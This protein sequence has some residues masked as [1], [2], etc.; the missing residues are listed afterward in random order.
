MSIE[1]LFANGN[2]PN[3]MIIITDQ[4]R[5]LSEWPEAYRSTLG[6]KLAA[7]QRLMTNGLYFEQAFT[8]AC[9]CS[10]SRAT[11]QTSQY[12]IVTG[13]TLT[14]E[15]ALPSPA[16]YANLTSV[17]SA[18]GYGCYWIGKWHLLWPNEPGTTNTDLTPWGWQAYG[19]PSPSSG[20][21]IYAWDPPDAGIT[22]DD[23]YL[24]GGTK[25]T[26]ATNRNDQR[27]VANA[28]SFLQAPPAGPW[29][30]VVSL[31]NP[32]DVHLG[33]EGL[34]HEFYERS[35]YEGLDVPLP[36]TVYQDVSKMPRGQSYSTWKNQSAGHH[37]TRHHF[38]DFYAYLVEYVDGQI[39]TILDAMNPSQVD[40]TLIVRFSDH[41]EMGL[42][43]NLVEKFVNA[44]GQCVHV[45]LVFSNPVAWPSA[46]TTQSLASTVDLVPTFAGLLGVQ[47]DQ[48]SFVGADLS[49][50]LVNPTQPVQDFVH[51]T[52]DDEGDT[53]VPS[54][55]R[56]IRSQQWAYAVYLDSV[57][58]ATSGYLDADWEM[59][60]LV[61]DPEER[62]NLAGQGL[63]QQDFLDSLLQAQMIL[64]N[65]APAWYETNWPPQKTANSIGGPPSGSASA[66]RPIA[67]L[68]GIT[69]RQV[70]ALSYAGVR[71]VPALLARTRSAAGRARLA[72]L[73]KLDPKQ[74]DKWIEAITRLLKTPPKRPAASHHKP[75][76]SA[77]ARTKARR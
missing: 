38:G 3:I 29:C 76:A 41:G 13:C 11:F 5:A 23:T 65:T 37:A 9:M 15:S 20:T 54:V 28:I 51:F 14:G 27:Y 16:V 40:D 63:E 60:D 72:N 57:T 44:Y 30:L 21:N 47:N 74:L 33:F 42:A 73:A 59:Y 56:A 64:K 34:A 19:P 26:K 32:H 71:S 17:L 77:R 55:I 62:V 70:E 58:S 25:G 31:V 48:W 39:G 6:G 49:A 2:K 45:P 75:K 46:A 61:K 68:P 22:L 53:S 24:G 52:Y 43:H 12:P 10:P 8:A 36:H 69:R 1:Q 4:E 67:K 66:A 7:M 18:A 35:A 50:V